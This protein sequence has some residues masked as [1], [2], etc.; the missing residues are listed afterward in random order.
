[1]TTDETERALREQLAT[2]ARV[3]AA[4]LDVAHRERD[5]ALARLDVVQAEADRAV[6]E[7]THFRD[8]ALARR[9]ELA[10][11]RDHWRERCEATQR[12][13]DDE[14][15]A[16]AKLREDLAAL[17]TALVNSRAACVE[18]QTRGFALA[19]QVRRLETELRELRFARP[20]VAAGAV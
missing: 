8:E 14:I 12:H 13:L 18:E 19:A 17:S 9:D 6:A 1:M 16:S 7:I 10:G 3:A 2:N 5:A 11:Q 4:T 20:R 15:A